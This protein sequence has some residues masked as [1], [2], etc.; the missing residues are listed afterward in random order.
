M[1]KYRIRT[2]YFLILGFSVALVALTGILNGNMNKTWADSNFTLED[3]LQDYYVKVEDKSDN[4]LEIRSDDSQD[5]DS[6]DLTG[7]A[8]SNDEN[9]D[10]ENETSNDSTS[11]LT[12]QEMNS[13]DTESSNQTSVGTA[14]SEASETSQ[15]INQ[16]TVNQNQV[17]NNQTVNI[18]NNVELKQRLEIAIS[19]EGNEV[20]ISIEEQNRIESSDRVIVTQYKS[21][22]G[23]NC[24]TGNVLAGAENEENLR[25]LSECQEATGVVM[26][27]KNMDDGDYKFFLNLDDKF[28]FL[29][30]EKNNDKTDGYLVVEISPPDQENSGVV[31]PKD[32]ERVHVW[33]AWVTDKPKGWHEM[34][35]AWKVINE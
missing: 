30:N 25:I 4:N 33:G 17:Q 24:R 15:N 5:S 31:L 3:M 26:H 12:G 35:P 22:T 7:Q 23:P 1:E 19:E 14:G 34:H 28:K 29:T 27:T 9:N 11:D 10:S 2:A 32:G 13:E 18:Q 8:M 6:S 20:P 21:L 16:T